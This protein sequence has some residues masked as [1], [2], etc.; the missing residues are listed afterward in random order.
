MNKPERKLV[1]VNVRL[2]EDDVEAVKVLAAKDRRSHHALIRELVS[3]ALR[4]R[5][6]VEIR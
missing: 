1:Q 2:F 3:E 4:R 5:T 6:K